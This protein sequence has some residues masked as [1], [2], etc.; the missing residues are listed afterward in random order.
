MRGLVVGLG[1]MG[2]RRVRLITGFFEGAELCG[3][4]SSAARRKEASELFS[5]ECFPSIKEAVEAFSPEAAF[6]CTSPLSHAVIIKELLSYNLNVFTEINLVSD[7]YE[8]N[9][10]TA[11][12]KG[13]TLFLSSTPLYRRETQFIEKT[14]KETKGALCYRY[15]VGQYLPDWH[16]WENYKDFFVGDRRTNGCREIF[17]IELPWLESAFGRVV[18][19]ESV[20]LKQTEL[21]IDYPDSYLVTLTHE[22]GAVGQFA[23]NVVSRKA[24]RDLEV[25]GEN[26]YLKWN[27]TP[28]GL[29]VYDI[30]S[31]TD[32]LIDTYESVT[33]DTRYAENI[34]ENAYVDELAAFFDILSGKP[35]RRHSFEED[36]AMLGVI[37]K[38]EGAA[39]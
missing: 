1:S 26:L 15:H 19:A 25:I 11:K 16:P 6:V 31:K 32:K 24:V 33:K 35:A 17:A 18:K 4:D 12:E 10:R 8:E 38:I 7:G 37:D 27:G 28:K 22:S 14:V 39:K 29:C 13:L 34:I 2:K 20:S 30:E 23:V 3:V 9:V 5:I 36:A 21:S